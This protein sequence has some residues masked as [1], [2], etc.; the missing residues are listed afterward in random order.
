MDVRLLTE[1]D[2]YNTLS[3]WWKSWRITPPSIDFLP[4][5]GTSGIMVSKDGVDVCAGFLYLTNSK[6]AWCEHIVSSIDVKDRDIRRDA[7]SLLIGTIS[8]IAKDKGCKFM[9][10]SIKDMSLAR[11]YGRNGYIKGSKNCQELIK[12][13]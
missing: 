10:A 4:M 3:G 1:D 12:V 11:Y 7:L 9:Y 6:V 5:N 13:L 2:Y 8:E